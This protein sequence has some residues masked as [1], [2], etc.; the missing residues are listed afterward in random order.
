[1]TEVKADHRPLVAAH[2]REKMRAR[3]VE[4]ALAVIAAKGIEGTVIEDVIAGAGVSRGTFY[5]HFTDIPE[6]MRV[7]RDAL[8][9]ESLVLSLAAVADVSD[10]AEACAKGLRI[11]LSISASFPLLA[12]FS[13]RIGLNMARRGNLVAVLLPPIL[14]RG[15]QQGRFCTMPVHL[16]VDCLAG[17]VI[18]AQQYQAEGLAL[19]MTELIA[20]AL[21][22]LAVDPAEANRLAALPVEEVHPPEGGLIS[23]SVPR[24]PESGHASLSLQTK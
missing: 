22:M 19:D 3:L 11:A 15:M 4:A 23:R 10:P 20:A 14:L 8:I 2:R 21:R 9:D 24:C 5:N 7:V 17:T 18:V 13:A 16:A 12:Q 1:M 6:L